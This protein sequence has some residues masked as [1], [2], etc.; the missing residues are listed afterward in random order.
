MNVGTLSWCIIFLSVSL[1]DILRARPA[2][3]LIFGLINAKPSIIDLKNGRTDEILGDIR[4]ENVYFAYPRRPLNNVANNL[5]LNAKSDQTIALV[6]PS[7]SGKSSIISLLE[8]FYEPKSG[9][10]VKIFQ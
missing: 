5:S 2:A 8:R 7:G 3:S 10:I 1:N 9:T 6:G 4:L